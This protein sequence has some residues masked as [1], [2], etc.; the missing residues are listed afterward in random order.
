MHID[1]GQKLVSKITASW[2]VEH[3]VHIVRYLHVNPEETEGGHV[4]EA[5]FSQPT[6]VKPAPIASVSVYFVVTDSMSPDSSDYDVMFN[7]EGEDLVYSIAVPQNFEGV[8]TFEYGTEGNRFTP[9]AFE[10]ILEKCLVKKLEIREKQDLEQDFERSRLEEWRHDDEDDE[11]F[12]EGEEGEDD[13]EV[14]QD[15][16]KPFIN[17][18]S[19][20]RAQSPLAGATLETGTLLANIFDAADEDNMNCLMHREV[21]SLLD[22]TLKTMGLSTWDI[23]MLMKEAIE[24][25]EGNVNYQPF[26]IAAP[27]LVES[28]GQRRAGFKKKMAGY[29]ASNPDCEDEEGGIRIIGIEDVEVFFSAEVEETARVMQEKFKEIDHSGDGLLSRKQMR[30]ALM[31][32]PD[33][34]SPQEA[35]L[36][37]QHFAQTDAGQIEYLEMIPH[38]T[39]TKVEFT[40]LQFEIFKLRVGALHNAIVE[41]DVFL[42][43]KHLVLLLRRCGMT[44]E[45]VDWRPW[46]FRQVLLMADQ[47]CLPRIVITILMSMMKGNHMGLV[48][49]MTF[50]ET[51]CRFIPDFYDVFEFQKTVMEIQ[52][53][54][55]EAQ[56]AAETAEL[57]K[58]TQ[59]M[60]GSM[61][62]KDANEELEENKP[63]PRDEVEKII[64]YEMQ[65]MDDRHKGV[66]SPEMVLTVLHSCSE[67]CK[68]LD[69]EV[70][71]L[72][73]E[74][75]VNDFGECSY[76]EFVKTWV[77]II[78]ECRERKTLNLEWKS[79]AVEPGELD[80]EVAAAMKLL[81]PL[82]VPLDELVAKFP[83][84]LDSDANAE[85]AGSRRLSS[86]RLSIGLSKNRAS[87]S[88]D[89]P[90]SH[91]GGGSKEGSRR[92][93]VRRS[94]AGLTQ[95]SM[96]AEQSAVA[97]SLS[98]VN[99]DMKRPSKMIIS[100]LTEPA[101]QAVEQK[102]AFRRIMKK[103]PA[104]SEDSGSLVDA[105]ASPKSNKKK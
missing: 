20:D 51:C 42:V 1:A 50:L 15:E 24:D 95:G 68:L 23:H 96:N 48:N 65:R 35:A 60:M 44:R 22:A 73:G 87:I 76:V 71:A 10:R 82:K 4:Y 103:A 94:Q 62:S 2:G 13:E 81:P 64:I 80:D 63:V 25:L 49:V 66:M 5:V 102:A 88:K 75:K 39:N 38:P 104:A 56:R 90:P 33:R 59:G 72:T 91:D 21:A 53:L 67:Q 6:K 78:F 40:P 85:G 26:V 19:T 7:I 31:A 3:F 8:A 32:R 28:L 105:D 17:L 30:E 58:L 61:G 36:L 93:I 98:K 57:E 84:F 99:P 52:R 70:R 55:E 69:Y 86:K 14:S 9:T 101:R 74:I 18:I 11:E 79:G 43:W 77:P 46:E 83:L 41:T 27:E 16:T 45:H 54:N 12:E 97:Q 100:R 29:L 34:F 37:M 92:S 47:L 89:V